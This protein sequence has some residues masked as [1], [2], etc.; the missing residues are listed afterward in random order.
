MDIMEK[1]KQEKQAQAA[2]DIFLDLE[3][4]N[5][6]EAL[7]VK[8]NV[9]CEQLKELLQQ[10]ELLLRVSPGLPEDI[11]GKLRQLVSPLP[12][13]T[14]APSKSPSKNR[15]EVKGPDGLV[16]LEGPYRSL[17]EQLENLVSEPL[18][19]KFV[20]REQRDKV[21]SWLSSR[22]FEGRWLD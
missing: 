2:E 10:G 16:V 9:W 17:Q 11:Q 19:F 6:I 13:S 5:I 20:W 14:Q 22:G 3:L 1:E 12:T 7:Q 4:K 18:P 21:L 15:L 8:K